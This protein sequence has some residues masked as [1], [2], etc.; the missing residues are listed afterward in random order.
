MVHKH[1]FGLKHHKL[2]TN[3]IISGL[4]RHEL[5]ECDYRE[6]ECVFKGCLEQIQLNK[7][8]E[9]LRMN[10]HHHFLPELESNQYGNGSTNR[11]SIKPWQG[12]TSEKIVYLKLNDKDRFFFG[13]LGEKLAF[14]CYLFYAL[15]VGSAEEAKKFVYELKIWGKS[16]KKVYCVTGPTKSLIHRFYG[17]K[18][19]NPNYYYE[20]PLD[21][22]RTFFDQDDVSISWEVSIK[23]KQK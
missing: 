11:G 21:T 17:Q 18:Y 16:S 3:F 20:L 12:L 6:I 23:E 5:E 4:S 7:Y 13:C 2:L 15:F 14:H 22:V 19:R 9:H 10:E 1:F 8:L